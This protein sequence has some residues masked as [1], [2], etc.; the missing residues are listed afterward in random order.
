MAEL[1]VDTVPFR[2]GNIFCIG[3]NYAAHAAE[4]G[5]ALEEEPL[6][7]L[8]PTSALIGEDAPITLPAYSQD[9]QHEAELVVL[10]GKGGADI[11]ESGALEHVAAYGI[12]LDLTARD[13]QSEAKRKGLP[14]VKAK[15]FRTAACVSA[16]VDARRVPDPQALH[17]SLTVNGETRQQGDTAMMLFSVANIVSTLSRIYGLAEG[18]LIYT[19]T[20]A[21]VSALASGDTVAVQLDGLVSAAWRVA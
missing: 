14:W 13:V 11:A 20:P 3:R 10:I 6:V 1:L 8:K 21:G 9:V 2:V 7:F 15:G 17:F 5:N 12:G 18:D 16:L 19:G 4:L